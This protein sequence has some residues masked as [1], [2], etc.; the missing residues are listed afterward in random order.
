MP[1]LFCYLASLLGA[2]VSHLAITIVIMY[3]NGPHKE[4]ILL[5]ENRTNMHVLN[6]NS[7]VKE[8]SKALLMRKKIQ[9]EE[10]TEMKLIH[11]T[12]I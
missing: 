1:R 11:E 2:L 8:S 3:D 6:T 12:K 4:Y 9:A 5:S 7:G 10:P